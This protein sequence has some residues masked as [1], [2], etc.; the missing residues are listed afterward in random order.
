MASTR[1]LYREQLDPA[2]PGR[3][4]DGDGWRRF[5]TPRGR[6]S[7]C[8][9]R[10]PRTLTIRSTLRGPVVNALVPA[11]EPRR[12]SA[13]VAA[14]GRHGASGRSARHAWA[15]RAPATGQ[16]F[17]ATLRDWA[18]P[19]FNWVFADRR[20]HHRLPDGRARSGARPHHPRLPRRRQ[21]GRSLAGLASR[22]RTCP[23]AATR[24][25]A[26]VASAN[27]RPLPPDDPR[28][29]YGAYSQGHRGV[30]ID[31]A[32]AAGTLG[33]RRQH[34][35]AERR[36]EHPGGAARA[37]H[38]APSRR[39]HRPRPRR[40]GV[41]PV[42]LGRALHAGEHARRRCSR[43]SCSSGSAASPPSICPSAC[44]T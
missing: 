17:R 21:P 31:A 3:Y 26:I 40:P 10:H 13:A 11:L 16:Q 7:R 27:Q 9:A 5:D 1:D 8:A 12:R 23:A 20:R 28:P 4:R 35:P 6:Q 38:P 30:R 32:F 43:P 15:C 41:R 29:I 42:R 44:W 33:L 37:A 19:V 34:P 39:P 25:A 36:A 14:L 22:S 2:D 18:L 24:P